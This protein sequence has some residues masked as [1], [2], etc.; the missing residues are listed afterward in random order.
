MLALGAK[1]NVQG[2]GHRS[3][4]AIF[5]REAQTVCRAADGGWGGEG[6]LASGEKPTTA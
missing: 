3:T 5:G 2:A 6:L 1:E 4:E